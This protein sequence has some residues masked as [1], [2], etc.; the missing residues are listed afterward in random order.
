MSVDVVRI[1]I[2]PRYTS[3]VGTGDLRSPP[4]DIRT[5]ADALFVGWQGNGL[6]ATA[7][8]LQF[9]LEFSMDLTTWIGAV[10]FPSSP[11]AVTEF[12][13]S[14]VLQY[15]WMRVK[16]VVTGA[17]PGISAWLTVDLTLR[18]NKAAGEAA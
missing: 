16:A 11:V 13:Q 7:A 9:T 1:V 18:R 10:T 14:I 8:T 15:P 3:F 6:G 2:F 4:I 5:F 12:V 17:D